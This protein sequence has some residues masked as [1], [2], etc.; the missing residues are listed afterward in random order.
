V[1]EAQRASNDETISAYTIGSFGR[2]RSLK[3]VQV[4]NSNEAIVDASEEWVWLY[5]FSTHGWTDGI[6]LS[7]PPRIVVV[8]TKRYDT[9]S[10]GT[11]TLPFAIPLDDVRNGLTDQGLDELLIFLRN[12]KK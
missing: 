5:G 11:K 10:G 7:S 2:P 6:L 4:L 9:V 12:E 8:T 1:W 3:V